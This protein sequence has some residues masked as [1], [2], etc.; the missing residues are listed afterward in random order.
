MIPSAKDTWPKVVLPGPA[1][2]FAR[3]SSILRE[4]DGFSIQIVTYK[5]GQ[6]SYPYLLHNCEPPDYKLNDAS[7]F[8]AE[9]TETAHCIYCNTTYPYISL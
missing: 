9:D 5:W 1:E 7:Y 2:T 6:I 8:L 3:S 4:Q